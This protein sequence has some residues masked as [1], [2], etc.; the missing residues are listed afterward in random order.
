MAAGVGAD[1]NNCIWSDWGEPFEVMTTYT[2]KARKPWVCCECGDAIALGQTYE[3]NT[4]LYEGE[5]SDYR[6]CARCAMV[7][8]DFFRG[9]TFCS[10]VEDFEDAHGFDYRKGIPADF[11]PCGATE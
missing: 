8:I 2:R 6:T 10:M 1:M 3:H 7:A 11:T 5:W 9:R 4:A